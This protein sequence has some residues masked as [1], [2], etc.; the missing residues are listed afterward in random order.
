MTFTM[1]FDAILWF[2]THYSTLFNIIKFGFAFVF[3]CTTVLAFTLNHKLQLDA[4][5]DG[6]RAE[7]ASLGRRAEMYLRAGRRNRRLL[8]RL[9]ELN[10]QLTERTAEAVLERAAKERNEGNHEHAAN[11][12]ADWLE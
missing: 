11:G 6:L 1:I 9:Q 7:L 8:S 2:K 5:L 4:R 3:A 10:L 12:L